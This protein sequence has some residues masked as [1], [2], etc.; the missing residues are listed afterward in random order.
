MAATYC[1]WPV[2]IIIAIVG[3]IVF[4]VLWCIIRCACCGLSCC[5]TCFSCLKCCDCCGCCSGCCDGRKDKPHKYLDEEYN[6]K[7]PR[8]LNQGYQAPMPMVTGAVAAPPQYAQFEVGKN[9]LAVTPA[10]VS[11]DALPPMPSWDS[12]SK[13]R[14]LQEDEKEGMEMSA[15]EP[16]TGQKVPL[17]AD[18]APTAVSSP[19]E[20]AFPTRS[21]QN[22][23]T[24]VATANP[25]NPYSS[26]ETAF[27]QNGRGFAGPQN[28]PGRYGSP[29]PSRFGSP[30]P[31]D[32][33]NGFGRPQPQRQFSNGPS[34]VNPQRQFSNDSYKS[35]P[36]RQYSGSNGQYPPGRAPSRGPGIPGG[37]NM[38]SSPM[39]DYNH[40]AIYS[41]PQQYHSPQPRPFGAPPPGAR[42]TPRLEQ[43]QSGNDRGGYFNQGSG[44]TAPPSYASRS[45]PPMNQE[46][47]YPGY[48]PY[49]PPSSQPGLQQQP[50]RWDP[51]YR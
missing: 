38:G 17:M 36:Q 39:N 31:Q 11:E 40:Q 2:I 34:R 45:P 29:S 47:T 16:S 46:P 21:G 4:S 5:C 43:Q 48:R 30:A 41:E 25:S 32:M 22:G 12:A 35:G 33:G 18:T 8:D 23:Y 49:Q 15:L 28:G 50:E 24:G 26:N 42:L 37:P 27:N 10:P 3:L 1:K 20:A 13:K 19:V 44:S 9:G 14:I 6:R 51:V 7:I